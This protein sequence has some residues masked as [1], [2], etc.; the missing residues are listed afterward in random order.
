MRTVVFALATTLTLGA[1]TTERTSESPTPPPPPLTVESLAQSTVSGILESPVTLTDGIYLGSPL[2]EGSP[3]APEVRWLPQIVHVT[4]L[5]GDGH[6]DA[7]AFF[8]SSSGGTGEYLHL[9]W[10][11][12]GARGPFSRAVHR[13]GDRVQVRSARWSEGEWVMRMIVAGPDD[14]LCCPTQ[15]EEQ[16]FRFDAEGT[17]ET[18]TSV[19]GTLDFGEIAGSSWRLERMDT[20]APE[21]EEVEVTLH[22]VE[23]G[24]FGSSGC[25]TYRGGIVTANTNGL[26]FGPLATTRMACPPP[27]SEVEAEYLARL[28]SVESWSF[29]MGRLALTHRHEDGF[30]SLIFVPTTRPSAE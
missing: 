17:I 14:P 3:A 16:R 26:S 28:N 4:D 23:G 20:G 25:N 24:V 15:I 9:A 27:Q 13:L 19:V 10:M 18:S 21:L 11:Q 2:A 22:F 5:D 8:S 12:S 1:C 6:E 29:L 7:I 30:A